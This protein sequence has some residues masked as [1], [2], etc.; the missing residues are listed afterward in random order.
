[1]PTPAET[2]YARL[3][4]KTKL[5]QGRLAQM[6]KR[7]ANQKKKIA[8]SAHRAGAFVR[9]KYLSDPFII[10]L[11]GTHGGLRAQN[12]GRLA[13]A[14]GKQHVQ[15][16]MTIGRNIKAQNNA[17]LVIAKRLYNAWYN[18]LTPN[19]KKQQARNYNR[20]LTGAAWYNLNIIRNMN[21]TNFGH[22]F[23][24]IPLYFASQTSAA[25]RV[26]NM[27]NLIWKR[28]LL[29]ANWRPR[30]EPYD[31]YRFFRRLQRGHDKNYHMNR[32]YTN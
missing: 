18:S 21:V 8:A 25:P 20:N 10:R 24:R 6:M 2:A 22:E 14:L 19:Q 17:K 28:N 15:P 13:I 31:R 16:T 5:E 12:M 23:V 4:R 11:L 30:N 32:R 7:I 9:N 27:K 29:A 26:K 1:M 3:Q